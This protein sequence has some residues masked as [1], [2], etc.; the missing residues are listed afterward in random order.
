M[1]LHTVNVNSAASGGVI[2]IYDGQDVT[3]TVVCV[4]DASTKSGSPHIY[5][6]KCLGGLF[7]VVSG[8]NID[9]TITLFEP[10]FHSSSYWAMPRLWDRAEPRVE[11]PSESHLP[12]LPPA[13][14]SVRARW[15]RAPAAMKAAA[16]ARG[17]RHARVGT[18]APVATGVDALGRPAPGRGISGAVGYP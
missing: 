13:R 14:F 7:A 16:C 17:T 15:R 1:T 2:T 3:G 10:P 12:P 9:A 11:K 18:R 5:G 4:I 6:C 8:A